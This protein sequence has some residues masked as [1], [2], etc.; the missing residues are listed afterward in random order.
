[1]Y[2]YLSNEKVMVK[3]RSLCLKSQLSIISKSLYSQTLLIRTSKGQNQV[4]SLQRCPYNRGRECMIL[5]FLGPNEL[6]IIERCPYYRGVRKE[7]LNCIEIS[8]R[9]A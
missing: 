5:A 3:K 1:M 2:I 7:R 4:S 8:I 9:L 6:S